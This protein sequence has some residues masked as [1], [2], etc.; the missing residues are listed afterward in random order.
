MSSQ[1]AIIFPTHFT[2]GK[3]SAFVSNEIVAH[4]LT[5]TQIWALLANITKWPSYY[6]NCAKIT[7]PK[8]DS[9]FLH[10]GDVFNFSTFGFSP[11]TCEVVESEAPESNGRAGWRGSVKRRGG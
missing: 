8:S 1:S 7:C 10:K 3:T 5:S 11:L 4:D 6:K 2:P 9:T